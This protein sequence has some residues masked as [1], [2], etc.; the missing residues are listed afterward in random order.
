MTLIN[1][2]LSLSHNII[3]LTILPASPPLSLSFTVLINLIRLNRVV[4]PKAINILIN[5]NKAAV[6]R[7]LLFIQRLNSSTR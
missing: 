2:K 4:L 3:T 6:L 7:T 1:L 5:V